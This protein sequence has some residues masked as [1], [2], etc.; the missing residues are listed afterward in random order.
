MSK[1]AIDLMP[2]IDAVLDAVMAFSHDER[3]A[4]GR[5]RDSMMSELQMAV[6]DLSDAVDK[7]D[8][9]RS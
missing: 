4:H 5:R 9:A 1:D 3:E 8:E 6:D 7:N 2:L